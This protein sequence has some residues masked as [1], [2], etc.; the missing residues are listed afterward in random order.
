MPPDPLPGHGHDGEQPEGARGPFPAP[1]ADEGPAEGA[2][3]GLYVC[4]PAEELTL[5]G[6]PRTGGQIR[7]RLA[8]CWPSSCTRSPG[9]TARAWRAVPTTSWLGS[10]PRAG[11]WNPVRPGR[12]WPR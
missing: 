2:E 10:S 1:D 11:E 3:Q 12:S 8:R 9:R 6:S 4:L 7:W 5:A